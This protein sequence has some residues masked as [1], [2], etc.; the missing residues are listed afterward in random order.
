VAVTPSP[1][2][3]ERETESAVSPTPRSTRFVAV[4]PDQESDYQPTPT[5]APQPTIQT[6]APVVV[7][8]RQEWLKDGGYIVWKLP[9]GIYQLELTS[10]SDGA[11]AEWSGTTNCD[12]TTRAM[13]SMTQRCQML[14]NPGQ[15]LI[16]NPTKFG[17]GP[18]ISINVKVTKLR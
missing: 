6:V 14:V 9:A 3:A 10:A 4:T 15:L 2:P 12:F 13:L 8:N 16:T 7:I 18:A 11:T 1:A 5:P 17:L